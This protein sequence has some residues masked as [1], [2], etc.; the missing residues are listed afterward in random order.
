MISRLAYAPME[1]KDLTPI[2]AYRKAKHEQ[3]ERYAFLSSCKKK[4]ICSVA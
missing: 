2:E 1:W 4:N 3:Q